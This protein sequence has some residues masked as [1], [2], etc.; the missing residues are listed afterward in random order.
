M[1]GEPTVLAA[2][3]PDE[4]KGC[5]FPASILK[6]LEAPPPDS[7]RSLALIGQHSGEPQAQVIGR[8]SRKRKFEMRGMN[9][10]VL[11][12]VLYTIW[13]AFEPTP[14]LSIRVSRT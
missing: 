13:C 3:P 14:N 9:H 11:T 2:L 1:S 8:H 4:R 5:A 10:P 12:C 7:M 6:H